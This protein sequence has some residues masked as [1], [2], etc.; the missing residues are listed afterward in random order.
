MSN[1]IFVI[2]FLFSAIHFLEFSSFYSRIAGIKT[3]Y[4]LVS[5]SIQQT[6][7]VLTRFFFIFLMPLIGFIVDKKI[8]QNIYIYMVLSSI[9]GASVSY[10]IAY[11]LKGKIIDFFSKVILEFNNKGYIISFYIG[12]KYFLKHLFDFKNSNFKFDK[13][14]LNYKIII[15]SSF[16]FCCYS[17]AVF[18][19]F[20]F[21][22]L[23]YDYRSTIS[24]LSGIINAF[25][26]VALTLYIEP[27]ISKAIDN[28]SINAE[29]DIYSLLIGR[30]I[31][32]SIISPV[33]VIIIASLT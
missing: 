29:N 11:V 26:T 6:T 12:F 20:Y 28:N 10:I 14:I 5:Y 1:I 8:Q 13:K 16:I 18:L 24:Q 2:I 23:Y 30:F 21:A 19:S 25:A 4:K 9:F 33:V 7:F 27:K 22:L 17:I 32:V 3:N 31:G 15:L